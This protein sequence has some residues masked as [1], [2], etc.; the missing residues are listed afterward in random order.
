MMGDV[1]ARGHPQDPGGRPAEARKSTS[2]AAKAAA[3]DAEQAHPPTWRTVVKR[4]LAVA[5][6]GVAV[7]L[8]LPTLIA[9]LGAWPRLSTLSPV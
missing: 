4:V 9:V 8:V 7:Y 2:V 6:T 3:I 1:T 5:V